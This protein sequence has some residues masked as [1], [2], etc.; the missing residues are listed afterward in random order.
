MRHSSSTALVGLLAVLDPVSAHP[1]SSSSAAAPADPT[2]T[3]FPS[4]FDITRSWANLSPYQDAPGFSEPKGMPRGCE[5][6]Q[7][8]VLHRHAQRYPTESDLDGGGM[9]AFAKK[10]KN[11]E[12]KHQ[13]SKIGHGPLSFLDDWEYLLGED[14]LLPTGAA[15]EATS[16]ANIWSR[17]GRLLYHAGRGQ[18][19][20]DESLN[21]FPNGTDR[22]KP[23]FR[24]TDQARILESARWWLSGFFGNTGA[25]NSYS[26][27]DLVI[28]HEGKGINNNTL[29]ADQACPGDIEEGNNSAER[30]I[31]RFTKAA[32]ERLSPYLPTDFDLDDSDILAML[33]MCPYEY[34]A[35]GSSTFCSLFTEQEWQDFE[36]NVDLQFYGDYG[37]GS[38]TGRSQGIGYVLEL[39]ARLQNHLIT[40]PET[41]INTTIDGNPH[42]FPLPDTQPLFMDMSHDNVI[43]AVLA[44]LGIDYFRYGPKGLPDTV[45]HAVPRTFRLNEVTP[46][47]A[48]LVSEIWRCPAQEELELDGAIYRNP[49]LSKEDTQS[50]I[51]FVLNGAPVPVNAVKGCEEGT[52]GAFCPVKGFVR[53]VQTLK[54][55]ADF[56]K[57]CFGKY[58]EG[59]QVGDGRPE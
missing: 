13:T 56:E 46:F 6:T 57:A 59:E 7:A 47:G 37:F 22:P 14:L 39:A 16:G 24:T 2:G 19:A 29:A 55:E 45:S 1:T 18:A 20:W 15:T 25:N 8:H 11:Y 28:T 43:V 41:S 58:H 12:H 38:P 10:L 44:A 48:H 35:L 3:T 9:E 36:Y 30:F 52:K 53:G 32:I 34:A 31:P 49:D 51:R 17:Y 27:Y 23:I 5:L 40:A 50:Y 4:E 42:T 33:N 26:Q 21:V 54:E